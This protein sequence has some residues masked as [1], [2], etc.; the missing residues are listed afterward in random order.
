MKA[1]VAATEGLRVRN[2]P[3]MDGKIIKTLKYRQPVE[4]DQIIKD[5][6]CKLLGTSSD[7][8]VHGAYLVPTDPKLPFVLPISASKINL[9][10][11][12][13]G[14][15][16]TPSQMKIVKGNHVNAVLI[17]T[18]QP[19]Y[20]DR[21][22]GLFR[23]SGVE[24]FVIRSTTPYFPRNGA[25]YAKLALPAVR[26]F[27][28]AIGTTKVMLQIHNEP[29]LYAEGLDKWES[30]H[31]YNKWFIDAFNVFVKALPG[32]K[33]GFSPL[34]PGGSVPNVR[35]DERLFINAC[36]G[37]IALC[38]WLA[39]HCYYGN[40]DAS[41]L[42]IP[43]KNWKTYAQGKPIVCTEAG[44][45]LNRQVTT[46]GVRNM[47]KAFAAVGVPA[48]AWILDAAGERSFEGQSWDRNN[49]LLPAFG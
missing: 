34:S 14:W 24:H 42:Y 22:I 33:V 2:A 26:A 32:I 49:I 35:Y 8:W 40:T 12:A 48:F 39:V 30:G 45:S 3:S 23:E 13:G 7:L 31:S 47:F 41:D 21:I 27:T 44:P 36:A 28:N 9:H 20:A 10:A 19:N 37:A 17:P 5:G 16:P 46:E 15:P 38:D 25:D 29:N 18:Y 43:I 1:Y 6:W 4:V 11:S